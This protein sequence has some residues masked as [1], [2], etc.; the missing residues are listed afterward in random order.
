MPDKSARSLPPDRLW[1]PMTVKWFVSIFGASLAYAVLRYHIMGDVTWAHF[2]L[3]ILNKAIS[4][5]AVGFISCSYLIGKIIHFHDHDKRLRLVAIK[6]CGL[7]GFFMAGIHALLSLC[8]LSPAYYGKYFLSDGRLNVEGEVSLT[9][10]VIALCLLTGPAIA[11]IP[12][13]AKA[14]GGM[15]W[16]RGQR[17]GYLTLALVAIHMVA[18]GWRGWLAPKGWH[19]GLPPIS[20]IA[21]IL[22]LIPLLVRT[23]LD[24][25]KRLNEDA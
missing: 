18:L 24:H 23:K 11:T 15:R 13:M 10:G 6:F 12:M 7:V 5:A 21:L 3:F 4:L 16:K 20:L 19:G 2:P 9:V 22:A 25:E 14:V 8:L 1:Q 17:M